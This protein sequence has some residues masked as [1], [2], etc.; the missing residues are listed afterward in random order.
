MTVRQVRFIAFQV[1]C[2][3]LVVTPVSSSGVMLRSA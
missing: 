3:F 2:T 1:L